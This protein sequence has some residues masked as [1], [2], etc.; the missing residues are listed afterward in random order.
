M[1]AS[2]FTIICYLYGA[3][4][5]GFM[6]KP[7]ARQLYYNNMGPAINGNSEQGTPVSG[8][9]LGPSNE[10][11]LNAVHGGGQAGWVV[12]KAYKHSVCGDASEAHVLHAQE[13]G[14]T[15]RKERG[16]AFDDDGAYGMQVPHTVSK[17][18]YS[19]GGDI[20][21]EIKITA[22]HYGWFEFR[23]C[24]H[25]TSALTTQACLNEHVLR[26]DREAMKHADNLPMRNDWNEKPAD[27]TDYVGLSAHNRCS[28][29][30]VLERFAWNISEGGQVP[31]GLCTT[32]FPHGTCCDVS[33]GYVQNEDDRN[34]D[35]WW[36]EV[37]VAR[38]C[39]DP[40]TNDQRWVLPASGSDYSMTYK[41]PSGV[42][43]EPPE[44]P[45]TLQWLYITGNSQDAYPEIFA[46]CADI[47]IHAANGSTPTSPTTVPTTAQ[48]T[49]APTASTTRAT[50]TSTASTTRATS[51]SAHTTSAAHTTTS[52]AGSGCVANSSSNQDVTDDNCAACPRGQTWW[53]CNVDG[54]C[55]GDCA[56]PTSLAGKAPR[57]KK[58]RRSKFLAKETL[59]MQFAAKA[60]KAA[61]SP[62]VAVGE[63][64]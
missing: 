53:P 16:G 57:R 52:G 40:N 3:E 56:P 62:T 35:Q 30:G 28:G 34:P 9:E 63:E 21:I 31:E 44:K 64:L 11:N 26:F 46:N 17:Q 23:L 14:S 43:C 8:L 47:Y 61:V 2:A 59:M 5:H 39:G 12:E 10:M 51:T 4:A 41:L 49:V 20:E 18:T 42:T 50:S 19:E 38:D 15:N 33:G 48:T 6:S 27:V 22:H 7:A 58:A 32:C 25:K 24:D 55:A 54:L 29:P 60:R 36:G 13:S 37:G 1:A 45:C